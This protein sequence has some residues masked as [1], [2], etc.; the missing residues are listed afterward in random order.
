MPC[1][2]CSDTRTGSE[3]NSC[4]AIKSRAPT[5]YTRYARAYHFTIVI[6]ILTMDISVNYSDLC[7]L[8]SF[9]LHLDAEI[10]LLSDYLT[11]LATQHEV[12][13]GRGCQKT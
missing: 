13:N 7:V 9:R 12:K 10:S 3:S 8:Q 1:A 4:T 2:E 6:I 11:V 5:A